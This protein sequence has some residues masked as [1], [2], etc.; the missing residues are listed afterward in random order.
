MV[1]FE[2]LGRRIP[3]GS[4]VKLIFLLTVTFYLAK[5]D[6]R[7]KKSLTEFLNLAKNA[8]ILLKNANISKIK[9]ALVLNYIFLK[10]Q[11]GM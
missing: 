10:L 4:S 8:D 3:H 11:L 6:N 9:S 1:N 7:S 2:Q 5:T